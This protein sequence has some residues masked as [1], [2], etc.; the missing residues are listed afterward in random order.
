MRKNEIAV[1]PYCD[2][3]KLAHGLREKKVVS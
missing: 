3:T 2:W 1:F